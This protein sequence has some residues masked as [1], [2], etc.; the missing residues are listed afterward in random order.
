MVVTKK[1]IMVVQIVKLF[2]ENQWLR[3]KNQIF[4]NY[5][6]VDDDDDDHDDSNIINNNNN[7]AEEQDTNK[8]NNNNNNIYMI[9]TVW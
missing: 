6:V 2:I 3:K 5:D 9:N 8:Y 4:V 7:D 1:K